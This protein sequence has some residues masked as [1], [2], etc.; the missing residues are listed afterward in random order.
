MSLWFDA[1]KGFYFYPETQQVQGG[2]LWVN[3]GSTYEKNVEPRN[4]LCVVK[5]GLYIPECKGTYKEFIDKI[6]EAESAFVVLL[7]ENI[8]LKT[9][10]THI[11]IDKL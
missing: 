11:Y 7:S 2:K 6:Q 3:K 4:D 8:G 1:Q 5:L 9:A 10:Q